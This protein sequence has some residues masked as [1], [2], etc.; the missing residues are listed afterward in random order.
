MNETTDTGKVIILHPDIENL[1]ADVDRLR[2]ELSMLVLEH[3]E[4]LYQEGRNIEMEYML[5]VGALEYKA[6][7]IECTIL[8]LKRKTELIQAKKNRQEKINL[9]NIEE[10]LDNSA[11]IYIKP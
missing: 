3:D 6:Y 1:K 10:T 2:V 5:S 11:F 7:E 4:L 9:A 8:R